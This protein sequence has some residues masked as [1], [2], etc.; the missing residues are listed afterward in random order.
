MIVTEQKPLGEILSAIKG[1]EKLVVIG[2]GSCATECQTGGEKEVEQLSRK[3]QENGYTILDKFIPEVN[4]DERIVK[5]AYRDHRGAVEKADALI[6]L[7]C[8]V[9]VQVWASVANKFVVP[10]LN[11]LFSGK[12]ERIGRYYQFCRQ[13]G[14]CILHLTGGICPIAR[15]SKGLLNGPCGGMYNGKCEVSGWTR[16]CAWYLI[17][18]RLKELNRLDAFTEVN[19]PKDWSKVNAYQEVLTR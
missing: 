1:F 5:L 19:L 17:Y 11:T 13:C 7:S 18:K 12:V 10:G 15:C 2:C 6:V 3:L 14:N 8:G 4:C 9:G 16:D